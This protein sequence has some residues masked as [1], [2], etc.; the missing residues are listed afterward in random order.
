MLRECLPFTSLQNTSEQNLLKHL[1]KAEAYD[2]IKKYIITRRHAAEGDK[3]MKRRFIKTL[4][5][6]AGAVSAA[7]ATA[8]TA[9]AE[10]ASSADTS[11]VK[12]PSMTPMIISLILML[13]VLY[14]MAI[15]PQKKQE[16]QLKELQNSIEVGDEVVT[17]GGI[18]GIVVRKAD[19]NVVIETGGE[20]NKLRIKTWAIAENVSAKERMEE[21]AGKKADTGVAAAGLSDEKENGKKKNSSEDDA[22]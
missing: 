9:F 5:V 12:Q 19:D 15:R 22:E 17:S 3:S 4:A 6:I 16:Q 11:A 8:A 1:Q 21:S 20:R 7:S 13:A 18:I 10:E 14:F 2:I